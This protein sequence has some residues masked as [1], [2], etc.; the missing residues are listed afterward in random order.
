[1]VAHHLLVRR[2]DAIVAPRI[3]EHPQKEKKGDRSR[4]KG[5]RIGKRRSCG[6]VCGADD[7]N[8]PKAR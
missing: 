6:F 8:R 2:L 7:Y 3:K 5:K 1:M 4:Q